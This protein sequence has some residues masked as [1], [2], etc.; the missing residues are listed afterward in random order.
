M[1]LVEQMGALKDKAH[2]SKSKSQSRRKVRKRSHVRC[3]VFGEIDASLDQLNF[4]VLR[5]L[6][7]KCLFW[8]SPDSVIFSTVISSGK[9]TMC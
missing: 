9:T 4:V 5:T 8:S 1:A 2:K 6:P 3:A 7:K